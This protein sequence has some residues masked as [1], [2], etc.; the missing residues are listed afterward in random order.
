MA[1]NHIHLP[2]KPTPL[3]PL[4]AV[5]FKR[6]NPLLSLLT[7]F[8]ITEPGIVP[9]M[10]SQKPGTPSSKESTRRI[11]GFTFSLPKSPAS[12]AERWHEVL[13]ESGNVV[14]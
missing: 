13:E 11:N 9:S 1:I 10:V 4:E 3:P 2:L 8:R 12:M 6:L 14:S 5:P 7:P